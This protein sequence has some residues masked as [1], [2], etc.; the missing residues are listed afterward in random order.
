MVPSRRQERR[1][2]V[3]EGRGQEGERPDMAQLGQVLLLRHVGEADQIREEHS[4]ATPDRDT[5]PAG[6]GQRRRHVYEHATEAHHHRAQRIRLVPGVVERDHRR[7]QDGGPHGRPAAAS[8]PRRGD[9]HGEDP[10]GEQ[11]EADREDLPRADAPRRNRALGPFPRVALT[12]EGVVQVHAPRVE[13][14]ECEREERQPA[15]VDRGAGQ[16]RPRE[17]VGPDGWQVRHPPKKQIRGQALTLTSN[18]SGPVHMRS[19]SEIKVRA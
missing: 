17:R 4:G 18:Q 9:A 5:D 12:V 8:W 13:Q 15:R 10:G 16:G 19:A 3:Q 6:G 11:P 7:Q 2:R 14:R 1:P